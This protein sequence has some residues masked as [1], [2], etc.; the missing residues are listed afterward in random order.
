VQNLVCDPPVRVTA[1]PPTTTSD[2]PPAIRFSK[3]FDGRDDYHGT[4]TPISKD[5]NGKVTG[6][7]ATVPGSITEAKWLRH[8]AG[9]AGLGV[10]PIRAD[11]KTCV[12]GAIDIDLK[13]LKSSGK[14]PEDFAAMVEDLGL[15]LIATYS[16][17]D[18]VH[19][20]HF[21]KDPISTAEMMARLEHYKKELGLPADNNI[22]EIFPK[23]AKFDATDKGRGSWINICYFGEGRRLCP[24]KGP[25][26]EFLDQAEKLA[27]AIAEEPELDD[28]ADEEPGAKP[29]VEELIART[30]KVLNGELNGVKKG[31]T[32]G[33]NDAA[34]SFFVWTRDYL[35]TRSEAQ[36]AIDDLVKALNEA[37][38][39]TPLYTRAEA[40]Q[41]LKSVY[42]NP[43]RPKMTTVEDYPHGFFLKDR[44]F[45]QGGAV[46]YSAAKEDGSKEYWKVCTPIKVDR[47]CRDVDTNE[48]YRLLKLRDCDGKVIRILLPARDIGPK[49]DWMAELRAMAD[50]R[51]YDSRTFPFF[52]S[53][54]HPEGRGIVAT[55]V[56]WCG[57]EKTIF[58]LPEKSFGSNEPVDLIDVRHR[59][60]VR[61]TAA[62]WRDHIGSLCRGNSLLIFAAN[63]SFTAVLAP[64]TTIFGKVNPGFHLYG[65]T[66]LGKTTAQWVAGSVVGGTLTGD[67]YWR[68]FNSTVVGFEMQAALHNC[69][70]LILDEIGVADG[71]KLGD[72]IYQFSQGEGRSRGTAKIQAARTPTW[73]GVLFTSGEKIPEEM[74]RESGRTPRGGQSVRLLNMPAT[75][76]EQIWIV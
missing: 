23:Q 17:S 8:F 31:G 65:E 75:K 60:Y 20:W 44:P 7:C 76:K 1:P 28:Q 15:P 37:K 74:I 51:V 6:D 29:P 73:D 36:E 35:Y 63:I 38:P 16:K 61:G 42:S 25:I 64:L 68:T 19:L 3:L 66:S 58:V 13:Y 70:P 39:E 57:P 40:R 46:L 45:K 69:L 18:G 53:H 52:W 59:L 14:T 27:A 48:V 22:V 47:I 56:G 49:N 10:I 41:T 30:V 72:M 4:F 12:F 67:H 43:P 5:K 71:A 32:A 34:F 26:E 21:V 62:E 2:P 11:N 54:Y 33:R 9:E 50:F 24:G 55:R